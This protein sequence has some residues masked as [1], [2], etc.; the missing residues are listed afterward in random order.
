[1]LAKCSVDGSEMGLF[2]SLL[3]RADCIP[4]VSETA[5]FEA[6][7]RDCTTPLKWG[8]LRLN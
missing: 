2:L 6:K 5:R 3:F 8:G 7:V 4:L 1:M